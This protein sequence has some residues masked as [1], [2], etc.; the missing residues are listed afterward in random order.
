MPTK[1]RRKKGDISEYYTE[2]IKQEA[3]SVFGP[4]LEKHNYPFPESW[5]DARVS[6]KSRLQFIVLGFLRR[7]NQLY[8]KKKPRQLSLK[9]TIYGDMQRKDSKEH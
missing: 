7:I 6:K 1:Q 3:I 4:F 8:F 5:G 9:G 2:E